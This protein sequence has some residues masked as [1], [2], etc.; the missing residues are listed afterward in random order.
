VYFL[1][2]K[3]GFE[4]GRKSG[5]MQSYSTGRVIHSIQLAGAFAC[6]WRLPIQCGLMELRIALA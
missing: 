4:S 5:W 2:K 1:L 6:H 3:D